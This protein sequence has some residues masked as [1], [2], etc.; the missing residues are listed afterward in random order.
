V[1]GDGVNQNEEDPYAD[2]KRHRL[3]PEMLAQLAVVP[4]QVRRRR[5]QFVKVPGIW[6]EKLARARCI[7]TYRLALHVL[8]R[9]WIGSG[10]PFTLSN[11]MTE[12]EGVTRWS[13]WRALTEL[14][15]L[16][17]ITIERRYRKSPR[18]LVVV[19]P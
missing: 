1:E 6:V 8:Y 13:K 7:A 10:E 4:R 12:M 15:Q 19:Q 3:T 5:A 11:G 2:L 14:E 18:I 17:L 16:G 9:H